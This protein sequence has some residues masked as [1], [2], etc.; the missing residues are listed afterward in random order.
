MQRAAR[1]A[2]LL[3]RARADRAG[4]TEEALISQLCNSSIIMFHLFLL[5]ALWLY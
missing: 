5:L 4:I 1:G 2:G 3:E